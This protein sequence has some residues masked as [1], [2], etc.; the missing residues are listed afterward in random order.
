MNSLQVS[1]T[2]ISNTAIRTGE[3]IA[4]SV[5]KNITNVTQTFA[6]YY[7]AFFLLLFIVITYALYVY[8][9]NLSTNVLV[10]TQLYLK[11]GP[12]KIDSKDIVNPAATSSSYSVWVYLNEKI[13]SGNGTIFQLNNVGKNSGYYEGKIDFTKK[14]CFGL[15]INDKN[16]LIF[17]TSDASFITMNNFPPKKWTNIFINIYDYSKSNNGI[18]ETF[19]DGK[20]TSNFNLIFNSNNINYNNNIENTEYDTICSYTVPQKDSL[21]DLQIIINEIKQSYIDCNNNINII[22]DTIDKLYTAYEKLTISKSGLATDN[23][24]NCINITGNIL[25][26]IYS[27]N[28]YLK[29]NNNKFDNFYIFY[30]NLINKYTTPK[31]TKVSVDENVLTL[32]YINNLKYK[33]Y[34][35][36]YDLENYKLQKEKLKKWCD[37]NKSNIT[38]LYLNDPTK[39]IDNSWNSI[40]SN[41]DSISIS[42][43]IK[44]YELLQKNPCIAQK[45][46]LNRFPSSSSQIILGG[47]DTPPDIILSNFVRWAYTQPHTTIWS[48]FTM[49]NNNNDTY[50]AK[51][52]LTS[53][54]NTYKALSLLGFTR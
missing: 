20:L 47:D 34:C 9:S 18:L 49:G 37:N 1:T 38:K 11:N 44:H 45:L 4:S 6:M 25:Y 41:I 5:N 53:E 46:F 27:N 42:N 39:T 26:N 31:L 28:S 50:D 35:R 16:D 36:N 51:L 8:Y 52:I 10:K 15:Y 7:V 12:Q 29:N 33:D 40:L 3:N 54:D 48:N 43:S 13:T 22:N 14:G 2:G 30:T 17:S 21:N 19:I 23:F 24:L 32:D